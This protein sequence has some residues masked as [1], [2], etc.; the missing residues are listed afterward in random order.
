MNERLK[1]VGNVWFKPKY[2][3]NIFSLNNIKNT[4]QG[5]YDRTHGNNFVVNQT[6]KS[7]MRFIIHREGIKYYNIMHQKVALV[8]IV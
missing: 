3:N 8:D 5:T 6:V 7:D 4:Y 1:G 2:I